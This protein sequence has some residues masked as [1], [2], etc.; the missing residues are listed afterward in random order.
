MIF[1][2]RLLETLMAMVLMMLALPVLLIS[3]AVV[4]VVD[5]GPVFYR[6]S[7]EGFRGQPFQLVKL[8]TMVRGAD[9]RLAELLAGDPVARHEYETFFRLEE[10]PR[11]L[12][13]VGQLFRRTSIDEIPQLWNV[14]RGDMSLVGPR[15]LAHDVAAMLDE[16]FLDRRREVRPG[17]TGLWQ[18]S[19]RSDLDRSGLV[20]MDCEYLEHRSLTLD[21]SILVKTPAAV[22]R[23]RGA[24]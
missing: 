9:S 11:L 16:T 1:V 22:L 24:Y 7:R 18:V 17:L 2:R 12:P 13:G 5:P 23:R 8:R 19:G 21:L 3:A 15:P 4:F 14:I 6:Q 20:K 10:D